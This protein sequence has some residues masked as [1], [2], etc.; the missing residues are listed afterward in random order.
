MKL[1]DLICLSV[2]LAVFSSFVAG[3][4]SQCIKLDKQVEVL[5]RKSE[6]MKF[7]SESFYNSCKGKGF[8]S[9][10]EWKAVCGTLWNLENIEWEK[11]GGEESGLYRGK[12]I[13]PY[14][15]GEVYGKK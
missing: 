7:I 8:S 2:I 10:D 6:S 3:F 12:W 13:G 9:L 11:Y 5:R 1:T 15:S 14:G 4:F